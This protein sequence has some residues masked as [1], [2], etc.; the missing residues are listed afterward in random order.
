MLEPLVS[1]IIP[2]Y[3]VFPY[4]REALDSVINQTYRN[5]EII[6][7]DDGSTDGSGAVCDEYRS[8]PRVTVIHQENRGLSAARN[9]GLNRM[10]G[11]YV[12]FLDPDDAFHLDAIE[13][14]L[15]VLIRENADMVTC[16]YE[17]AETEGLLADAKT[18]IRV[19][20]E[21]E[22]VLT[23]REVFMAMLEGNYTIS[24][25]N[26]IYREKVWE[27]IR[28]PEGR[29]YEDVLVAPLIVEQCERIAVIP[30]VLIYY[31]KRPGSITQTCTVENI[32]S[33]IY[34]HNKVR[35]YLEK[36]SPS[37]S[38]EHVKRCYENDIRSMIL[39][40]AELRKKNGF[41]EV[42]ECLKEEIIRLAG[43][44]PLFY[45][46]KSKVVWRLFRTCPVMLI[47][48]R[49]CFR[50]IKRLLR[51]EKERRVVA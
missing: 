27:Q 43:E 28:F 19:I 50:R 30:K 15:N 23:P 3:N 1:V 2:V 39:G 12:S 40:W 4:L 38:P 20:P 49:V 35:E 6:I 45:K 37:F 32:R 14:F 5:Q 44:N 7:V 41:S 26:K 33:R 17:A 16:G 11:E 22:T 9:A 10:T 46:T 13:Y 48:A 36:V 8:D 42:T 34:A 18:D 51:K 31:R 21:K 29:I 47:P 24:A 25:W